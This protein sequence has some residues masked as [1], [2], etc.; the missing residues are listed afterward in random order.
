[1]VKMELECSEVEGIAVCFDNNLQS[2]AFL[3]FDK[4]SEFHPKIFIKCAFPGIGN[5]QI[6]L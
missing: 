6:N 4:S 2:E 5:P 3:C 1:M